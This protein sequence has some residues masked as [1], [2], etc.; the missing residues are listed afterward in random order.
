MKSEQLL[1]CWW[2]QYQKRQS[3]V[4]ENSLEIADIVVS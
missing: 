4:M 3:W 2:N 1:S